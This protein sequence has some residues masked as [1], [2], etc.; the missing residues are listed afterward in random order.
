VL[1]GFARRRLICT[2]DPLM[3]HVQSPV[4]AIEVGSGSARLAGML[5]DAA[6][7]WY[8]TLVDRS[9]AAVRFAAGLHAARG[10]SDRVRCIHGDIAALPVP[11]ESADVVIAAEVLE[12]APDPRH[13]AAELLRVLRP[14]GWRAISLPVDLDIALHPTVF[15]SEEEI[16]AFFASF[17][18][19]LRETTCVAP[20]RDLDAVADVFPGFPGCVNA[21]FR[22]PSC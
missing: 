15:G 8:L 12:H 14:G 13:S 4:H 9:H 3:R 18:L 10:T 2:R 6:P 5:A 21:I 16:L 11:N 22:K 17:G 1:L 7:H 19:A 20:D